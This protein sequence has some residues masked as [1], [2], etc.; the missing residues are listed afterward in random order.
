MVIK[1]IDIVEHLSGRGIVF[2][3]DGEELGQAS[4]EIDVL[5]TI[6]DVGTRDDPDAELE[7]LKETGG[8]FL[9]FDLTA[10]MIEGKTLSVHLE[11]GRHLDIIPH[12]AENFEGTVPQVRSGP[13]VI[14]RTRH[15]PLTNAVGGRRAHF[16][17]HS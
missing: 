8:R 10:A 15:R 9:D 4:Y 11:D 3:K 14:P 5:Q 1:R 13:A 17:G 6:I 2:E 7:G 16:R 12:D